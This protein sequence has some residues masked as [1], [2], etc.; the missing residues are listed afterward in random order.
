MYIIIYIPCLG[1]VK[2]QING[3]MTLC[4]PL[5]PNDSMLQC[6]KNL[7]FCRGRNIMI[8]FTELAN[9]KEPWRYRTDVLK[10]G[11]IGGYCKFNQDLLV[12]QMGH[13]GAL[14]SWAPEIQ[15]FVELKERPI[16][17]N[18][19]DL[20]YEKPVYIMKIDASKFES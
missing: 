3:M 7:G 10:T 13:M 14:Q 17:E 15:N 8:N 12:D 19:C 16:D 2:N 4:A 20:V 6:S 11:Q 18:K 5:F 1:Y 9:L